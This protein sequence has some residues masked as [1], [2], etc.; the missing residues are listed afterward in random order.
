MKLFAGS[1]LL[2]VLT[3]VC[4][5]QYYYKD[6]VVAGENKA[7]WRLYKDL[8]VKSVN[9]S[10]FEGDGRPSEGFLGDQQTTDNLSRITTH[11][12]AA[13]APETW[14]IASWSPQGLALRITD[15]SDTYSSVSDYQYDAQGRITSILNTS[16]E[17]DNHLRDIEQHIWQYGSGNQPST[18][19]KIKNGQDTTVVRFVLDEKGNVAEE[20]ARRNGID[21]PVVYYYYDANNHLTDVVRYNNKARRLLPDYV[22]EYDDQGKK[23]STLVVPEGSSNYQKWVYEY[24]EQGLKTKEACFNKQR[25][26]LG[27]IEYQYSFK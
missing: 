21:L 24:N 23:I 16:T 5:A 4:K 6:L 14:I 12:R 10:S 20:R 17:T 19:L 2:I 3:Q 9:L 15:T 25:E 8:K 26:L 13:G 11:T 1:L 22:F 27:K 18:M 7:Q